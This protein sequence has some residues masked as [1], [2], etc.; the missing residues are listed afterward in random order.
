MEDLYKIH[1]NLGFY[2]GFTARTMKSALTKA[3]VAAGYDITS[4]QW[5]MLMMLSRRGSRP[6][7]EIILDSYREKTTVARL[8]SGLEKKGLIERARGVEDKRSK[9]VFITGAGRELL[10]KLMPIARK[11]LN[12]SVKG[13]PQKDISV[14]KKSLY[15]IYENLSK[16]IR[17]PITES[18]E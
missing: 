9:I 18:H 11:V 2:I 14:L 5:Q 6:Q 13:I 16:E 10:E 15:K 4:D 17:S 12:E 1:D 3:F 7:G 8:I